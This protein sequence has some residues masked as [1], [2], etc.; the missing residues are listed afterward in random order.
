[1]GY[2]N[3]CRLSEAYHPYFVMKPRIR[4]RK[5]L[6]LISLPLWWD[7]SCALGSCIKLLERESV[8]N[9]TFECG[10]KPIRAPHSGA[11]QVLNANF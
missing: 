4:R 1:M 6:H 3:L 2:F 5:S 10:G 9:F 7:G 8:G 11:L